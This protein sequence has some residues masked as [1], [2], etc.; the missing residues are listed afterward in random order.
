MQQIITVFGGSQPQKG[1]EPYLQA[2][3][4]G[5]LLAENGFTTM[6]G[7]YIGTMEAVSKGAAEAGGHVIGV[8]CDEIESWRPVA[9]NEWVAEQRRYPLLRDRLYA[10][11]DDCDAAIALPGG[12]GT[13]AEI[14]VMWSQMQTGASALKPLILLGTQW[15]IIIE[16]IYQL[17][18]GYIPPAN[19]NLLS[20]CKD[21]IASVEHLKRSL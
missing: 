2:E 16:E 18:D 19:K 13:L 8:T 4:L 12:I 7:G 9:P 21:N 20:F 11:I 5:K 15:R 10:L 1:S 17:F 14:S 3:R 6:T